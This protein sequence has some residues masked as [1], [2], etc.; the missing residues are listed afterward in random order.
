MDGFNLLF[1]LLT[2]SRTITVYE[3]SSTALPSSVTSGVAS[4]T[5]ASTGVYTAPTPTGSPIFTGAGAMNGVSGSA[6]GLIVAGGVALVSI[7]DS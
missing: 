3:C 4:S 6:L 5:V 1:S 2:S 7:L